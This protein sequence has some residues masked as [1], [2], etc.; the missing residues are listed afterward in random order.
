[1]NKSLIETIAEQAITAVETR[2][3]TGDCEMSKYNLKFAELIVAECS[4][5]CG[6]ID[7]EAMLKHFGV[8]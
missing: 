4:E 5:F 6:R 2:P 1:M 3:G 8:E 7:R